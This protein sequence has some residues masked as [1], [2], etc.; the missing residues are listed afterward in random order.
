[1]EPLIFPIDLSCAQLCSLKNIKWKTTKKQPPDQH[2]A[3]ERFACI[4]K[5]IQ[6]ISNL[7]AR[8]LAM[9]PVMNLSAQLAL[10]I[11]QTL[12]MVLVMNLSAL[13]QLSAQLVL[14]IAQTLAMGV[15]LHW[16]HS[17]PCRTMTPCTCRTTPF[18]RNNRSKVV[19]M[20]KMGI[21]TKDSNFRPLTLA[22][23]T[24]SKFRSLSVS[25]VIMISHKNGTPDL[26]ERYLSSKPTQSDDSPG[27]VLAETMWGTPI[28]CCTRLI[29]WQELVQSRIQIYFNWDLQIQMM[30]LETPR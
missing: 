29:K 24:H 1:M 28:L 8:T 22:L 19:T 5:T 25:P 30:P 10:I 6:F 21:R 2:P 12:A 20:I 26:Q 18:Q 9:V 14:I 27:V 7:L 13:S 17:T 15:I 16:I 3:V 4:F 23:I 11:A